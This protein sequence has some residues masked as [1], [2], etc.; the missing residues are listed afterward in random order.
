[1]GRLFGYVR[2]GPRS[3]HVKHRALQQATVLDCLC[4]ALGRQMDA[5][6]LDASVSGRVPFHER[7]Q[8]SQLASLLEPGDIILA[9]RLSRLSRSLTGLLSLE[10][11]FQKRGVGVVTASGTWIQADKGF[12]ATPA[13]GSSP[14]SP[15]A[16]AHP[17]AQARTRRQLGFTPP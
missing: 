6:F 7:P 1:M 12:I 16:K 4:V 11:W 13:P 17:A 10:T 8:G 9:A 14:L 3:H 15:A 5:L 2:V